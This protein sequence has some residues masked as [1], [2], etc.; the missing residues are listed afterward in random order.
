MNNHSKPWKGYNIQNTMPITRPCRTEMRSWG[1]KT[2][3]QLVGTH[4]KCTLYRHVLFAP[5]MHFPTQKA[6]P[7]LLHRNARNHSNNL[8]NTRTRHIF[9]PGS[10]ILSTPPNQTMSASGRACS[11]A[12]PPRK[13]CRPRGIL[14]VCQECRPREPASMFAP[15]VGY[16]RIES[17]G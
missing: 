3:T 17:R 2:E 11:I 13:A 10:R 6:G 7:Q 4:G 9:A 16:R 12:C 8:P 14:S 1:L 5:M 15:P